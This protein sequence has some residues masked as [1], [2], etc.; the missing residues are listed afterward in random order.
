M[1]T[2]LE[3]VEE[4]DTNTIIIME[5][6]EAL[7]VAP[8]TSPGAHPTPRI[9]H[10]LKPTLPTSINLPSSL[11][12]SS[13]TTNKYPFNVFFNGWRYPQKHWKNWADR[14][15]FLHKS[16]WIKAG[17][18]DTVINSTFAIP[19]NEALL[20]GFAER[21]CSHTNTF[22][23]PFGESTLTL[24][25][26]MVLGGYSVLGDSVLETTQLI[27]IEE[28]L[29]QARLELSRTTAHKAVHYSWMV[30]FMGSGSEIEHEAFLVLWLSRFVFPSSSRDTIRKNVFPIA[31][32]LARG[33]KIA[34]APAVL[35][36][37]YRDLSL[38]KNA[39]VDCTTKYEDDSDEVLSVTVWGTL[40]L[41]QV[42][43]W[44]RFPTIGPK[45]NLVEN[46]VPRLARWHNLKQVMSIENVRSG[47]DSSSDH[48]RWRPYSIF[49]NNC[50][51]FKFYKE[52]DEWVSF[53]SNNEDLVAFARCLRV[54]ELV[55]LEC[56]EHYLPHRVA[57]QFGFDQ[58]LPGHVDRANRTPEIAWRNYTRP[59]GDKML[60]FP[61]RLFEADVTTRYLEWWKHL[62]LKEMN[63]AS[64]NGAENEKLSSMSTR[65]SKAN[66]S[67]CRKADNDADVPPGFHPKCSKVELM[68]SVD[69]DKLAV[70]E[71]V[72]RRRTGNGEASMGAPLQS[73][74]SYVA[75]DE[76]VQKVKSSVFRSTVK[77]EP[78]VEELEK[79][80][81][82]VMENGGTSVAHNSVR[83]NSNEGE[84]SILLTDEQLG[85]GVHLETRISK[86]E[87]KV[88]KLKAAKAK[89]IGKNFPKFI[90]PRI[91]TR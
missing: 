22:L 86:L 30:K 28:K 34:L 36:T 6:R 66:C 54:S 47:L 65:R 90:K 77:S 21:W 89:V 11:S 24:E 38:L 48:F 29:E 19:R 16:T 76:S 5:E 42:W 55:G 26:M 61:S 32:L 20:L 73:L 43:I 14:L 13:F 72:R 74:V 80:A 57:M 64:N 44:E 70:A 62:V 88:A 69:E 4:E 56:I 33:T 10:F 68:N 39:I 15:H 1:T 45:P 9:S 87:R 58:D 81:F 75:D 7:M 23:F 82:N 50:F 78:I 37:I 71:I 79:T 3:E 85:I 53:D 2:S 35:S 41:V 17:I 63:D 46:G 25:D 40:Q 8:P 83:G 31:I 60:Y 59:V 52:E 51:S 49:V 12:L 67:K 18:N 27:E 84:S 91:R